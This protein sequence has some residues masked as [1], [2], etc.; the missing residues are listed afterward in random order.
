MLGPALMYLGIRRFPG[1]T[2][3]CVSLQQGGHDWEGVARQPFP[4]KNAEQSLLQHRDLQGNEKVDQSAK[5]GALHV[6][7]A[8][9][10]TS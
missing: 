7:L 9:A 10:F 2:L 6:M 5:S 1:G 3:I 4:R 8:Q